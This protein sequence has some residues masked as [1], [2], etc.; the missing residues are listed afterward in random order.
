M[1]PRLAI[2]V[3]TD[4]SQVRSVRASAGAAD[5]VEGLAE[6]VGDRV[7]RGDGVLAG[8]DLDGAVAACGLHEFPDRPGGL[9]FRSTGR[10]PGLRRRCSGALRWNRACDG[11]WAWPA[12]RAWTCGTTRSEERR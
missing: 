6:V 5:D 9:C 2:Q 3:R 11:R 8:L 4:S 1:D 10:Q 7:S 12:G